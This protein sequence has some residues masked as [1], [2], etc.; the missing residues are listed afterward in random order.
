M[1]SDY[2][3]IL[4]AT[5]ACPLESWLSFL[6]RFI[7]RGRNLFCA[8]DLDSLGL[9]TKQAPKKPSMLETT[10]RPIDSRLTQAYFQCNLVTC[11]KINK[12]NL[13]KEIC[14]VHPNDPKCTK[15][16]AFAYSNIMV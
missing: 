9:Q 6:C 16:V 4:Y 14:H 5:P 3:F 12:S 10:S 15:K 11:N 1:R 7:L 13:F 8:L 2:L